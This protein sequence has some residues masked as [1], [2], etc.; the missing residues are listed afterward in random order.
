MNT[1]TLPIVLWYRMGSFTLVQKTFILKFG[2]LD[3]YSL[4]HNYVTMVPVLHW[5]LTMIYGFPELTD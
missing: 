3:F 4:V 5:Q 2:W 1:F